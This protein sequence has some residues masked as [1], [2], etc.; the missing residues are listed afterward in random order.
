[1]QS[2][3]PAMGRQDIEVTVVAEGAGRLGQNSASFIPRAI[4]FWRRKCVLVSSEVT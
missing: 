2:R 1:M 3:L 4:L